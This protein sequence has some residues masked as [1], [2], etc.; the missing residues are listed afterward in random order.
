MD[1]LFLSTVLFCLI[2]VNI[3]VSIAFSKCFNK[4]SSRLFWSILLLTAS[5]VLVGLISN[6]KP[7]I[8]RLFITGSILCLALRFVT[9]AT[10]R[11]EKYV[12]IKI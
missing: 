9:R 7:E 6:L 11:V 10:S 2:I 8:I 3:S 5:P 12:K 4:S 1:S